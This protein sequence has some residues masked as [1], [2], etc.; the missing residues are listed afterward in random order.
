VPRLLA[1][2]AE[3]VVFEVA[4]PREHP[5]GGAFHGHHGVSRFLAA[6]VGT[7]DLL[8]FAP[9]DTFHGAGHVVVVGRERGRVKRTGR[10]YATPWV[11]VWEV[12]DGKV[13]RFREFLDTATFLAAART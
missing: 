12:R 3:D 10:E 11:H 9:G 4:A 6:I 8:E 7:V 5:Y 13:A 2:C 1:C